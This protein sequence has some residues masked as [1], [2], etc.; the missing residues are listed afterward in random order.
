M[1]KAL[2]GKAYNITGRL[3]PS[4]PA[5]KTLNEETARGEIVICLCLINSLKMLLCTGHLMGG[6]SV[7]KRGLL[8]HFRYLN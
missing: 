2:H 4:L 7:I 8:T 5:M 1:G 3:A 6:S